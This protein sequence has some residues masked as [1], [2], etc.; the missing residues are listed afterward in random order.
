MQAEDCIL[1]NYDVIGMHINLS[2]EA[3]IGKI[4]AGA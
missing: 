3:F 2:M 4:G 1:C